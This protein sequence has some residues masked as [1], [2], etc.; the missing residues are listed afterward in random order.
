MG[1]SLVAGLAVG[2]LGAPQAAKATQA[3]E[4]GAISGQGS[5][6]KSLLEAVAL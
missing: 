4:G 5:A 3:Q 6:V 1:L 2:V